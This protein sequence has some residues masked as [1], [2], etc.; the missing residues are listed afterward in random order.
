MITNIL[1]PIDFSDCSKFAVKIAVDL[2]KKSNSKI[3]LLHFIMN[4]NLGFGYN[5]IK[6]KFNELFPHHIFNGTD[7]EL[8]IKIDN[9]YSQI[10]KYEKENNIDFIIIGSIKDPDCINSLSFQLKINATSPVLAVRS[11]LFRKENNI[12]HEHNVLIEQKNFVISSKQKEITDSLYYAK[13]IQNAIL[14]SEHITKKYLKNYFILYKPKDIVAG[15]FYWLEVIQL[16]RHSGLDPESHQKIAVQDHNDVILFAVADCTGHGVPGAMVSVVCKNALNHAVRD[17]GLTDP[18]LILDTT[19]NIINM[20]FEKSDDEEAIEVVNDG[21][22][23]ALCYLEGRILKYAGAN[24]S[25]WM[26][27]N[28]E[29]LETKGNRQPIGKFDFPSPFTTHT[30]ELQVGDTIYIF[31]DGY[32]DQFGGDKGKKFKTAK[33]KELILSIQHEDMD[34]QQKII[35]QTFEIWKGNLEQVDDVCIVGVRI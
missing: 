22:D 10:I 8:L 32:V 25:L 15:D 23:I 35:N 34:I 31:S 12:L 7:Y 13:R 1:V 29:L 33:F 24:N 14:P 19:R 21:M 16:N 18:G 17:H 11:E 3:H 28:G 26:I 30:V 9:I 20:E 2:A 6:S 4:D 5:E 27:R